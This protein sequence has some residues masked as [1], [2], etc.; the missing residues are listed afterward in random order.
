MDLLD[1]RPQPGRNL[2]TGHVDSQY[3][4]LAGL[5]G[6]DEAD[7]KEFGAAHRFPTDDM[8]RCDHEYPRT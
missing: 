6:V 8:G 1:V 3:G 2:A 4:L 5:Q 7:I